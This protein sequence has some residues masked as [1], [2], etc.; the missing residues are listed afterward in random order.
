MKKASPK[1]K[2]IRSRLLV[3]ERF[4]ADFRAFDE[5]RLLDD[6]SRKEKPQPPVDP[7][8]WRKFGT[9]G[10]RVNPLQAEKV[11]AF[12]VAQASTR[13]D[14]I[15]EM[16]KS[17]LRTKTPPLALPEEARDLIWSWQLLET[18]LDFA[19]EELVRRLPSWD[20]LI[21]F[22]TYYFARRKRLKDEDY[23]RC[24]DKKQ[25][26]VESVLD[27]YDEDVYCQALRILRKLAEPAFYEYLINIEA[28]LMS[29][30]EL[31]HF[32][33]AQVS[34]L[35]RKVRLSDEGKLTTQFGFHMEFDL[36]QYS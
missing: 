5:R 8:T 20:K 28:R 9:P 12:L 32:L 14:E 17:L 7:V 33:A 4:A 23:A 15:D 11:R 36:T 31:K 21:L 16:F 29:D 10:V 3:T 13:Q 6:S 22:A 27:Y 30:Q 1:K 25:P 2:D 24:K 19:P 18:L 34:C 26:P 35:D